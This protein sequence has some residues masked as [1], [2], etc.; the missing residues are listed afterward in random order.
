MPI[1]VDANKTS[2]LRSNFTK[3][4][5]LGEALFTLSAFWNNPRLSFTIQ[6]LKAQVSWVSLGV[7]CHLPMCDHLRTLF[8]SSKPLLWKVNIKE[9]KEMPAI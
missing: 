4:E 9:A 6:N 3:H 2:M 5:G 1:L 8:G 7:T